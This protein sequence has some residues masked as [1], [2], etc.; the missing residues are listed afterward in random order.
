TDGAA[1]GRPG[2]DRIEPD[3]EPVDVLTSGILGTPYYMAPEQF[4]CHADGLTDVWGLGV[5]LYELLTLCRPFNSKE[6]TLIADPRRPRDL[7]VD[8]PPDLEAICLK[9]IRRAPEE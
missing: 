8:L 7:I 1:L 2:Q 5:T 6:Q 9:A 4:D 3:P